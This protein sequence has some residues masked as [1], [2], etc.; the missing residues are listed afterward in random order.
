MNVYNY[1]KETGVY[2]ST[3]PAVESPLEPGVYL[4]PANATTTPVPL[5]PAGQ[6]AI[7]K[8]GAWTVTLIPPLQPDEP[9]TPVPPVAPLPPAAPTLTPA[10][11]RGAAYREESDPIFFKWQRGEATQADW[12]AAVEA[13][14][15]R[16][17]E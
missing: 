6:Q 14:K 10:Q 2:I 4:V 15:T 8:D 12:L 5:A 17:P 9:A 3:E 16:F 7:W 11:L 1:A 13:V